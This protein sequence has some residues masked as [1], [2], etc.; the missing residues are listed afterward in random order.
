VSGDERGV[1]ATVAGRLALAA[2]ADARATLVVDVDAEGSAVAGYYGERPEPGF[3]DALA[4]VRLWR[5]V[6][7]PI[8]ASDGLSID[9]IPGG[10]IRTEEP[11]R[12]TK[13][14]AREE[15]ARFRAEYDFCVIVAP[16]EASLTLACS[17]VEKPVTVHCAEIARTTLSRL[18]ADAARVRDSGALLHGLAIWDAELP[19]LAPR[20]ELMTK[21]MA[22]RARRPTPEGQ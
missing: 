7:R 20:S 1:V 22:A 16:S 15:F 2:A 5:E 4:G 21:H 11:D 9:V 6:T 14:S 10:A 19:Q 3:S 13:D 8:G 12:A 18:K 17:L